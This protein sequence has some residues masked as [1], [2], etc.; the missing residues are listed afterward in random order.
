VGYNVVDLDSKLKELSNRVIKDIKLQIDGIDNFNFISIV[1]ELVES[2]VRDMLT[3]DD[4]FL[5]YRRDSDNL[6]ARD[7]ND[8]TRS[9]IVYIEPKGRNYFITGD[10][11][12][13]RIGVLVRN[14]VIG[15]KIARKYNFSAKI[16]ENGGLTNE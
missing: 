9:V 8:K 14:H 1:G 5:S 3:S 7:V 6:N 13:L 11:V 12:N 16:K 2:S 10:T 4:V 15:Y